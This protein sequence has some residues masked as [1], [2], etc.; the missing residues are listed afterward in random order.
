MVRRTADRAVCNF[1]CK[2]DRRHMFE[3]C[4]LHRGGGHQGKDFVGLLAKRG[5]WVF[6]F[7]ANSRKMT[8][9]GPNGGRPL[10]VSNTAPSLAQPI[11][12]I[13][14]GPDG[15]G[16][17]P[18][19]SGPTRMFFMGGA[20]E[21]AGYTVPRRTRGGAKVCADFPKK[22]VSQNRKKSGFP[23]NGPRKCPIPGLEDVVSGV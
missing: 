16:G 19:P 3:H 5:N 18:E 17:P 2:T 7:L 6:P 20:R 23:E 10:L 12:N 21:G 8:K 14:V 11:K 1:S 15:S 4:T 13:L 9:T 22:W